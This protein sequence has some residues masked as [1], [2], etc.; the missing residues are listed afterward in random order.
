MGCTHTSRL[1]ASARVSFNYQNENNDP[2]VEFWIGWLRVI[3]AKSGNCKHLVRV[4]TEDTFKDARFPETSIATRDRDTAETEILQKGLLW[5]R[6][7]R[8][9]E[10]NGLESTWNRIYATCYIHWRDRHTQLLT[11]RM[12]NLKDGPWR[13]TNA[14]NESEGYREL[15]RY[16][17]VCNRW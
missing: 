9:L 16:D 14:I 8:G 10:I 2:I 7:T 11:K 13:G 5:L 17:F 15:R 6:D 1:D 12:G 4:D 3:C